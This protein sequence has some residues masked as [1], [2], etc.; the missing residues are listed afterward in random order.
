M[1]LSHLVGK[2]YK[3]RPS[4]ALLESHAILVR[5]GYIR[6][7]ANGIFSLLPPAHRIAQ[8]I[9]HII[10]EE[11]DRIGGQE[12]LMPVVLPA[13]LWK[14]SGRYDSVG[15]ELLRLSD[16]A[17]HQLL[18][19]MTHEEGVL[20]LARHE[21]TSYRNYPF[22][23][24]QFQTKFRDEPRA[25]GGL[26]R[27]REFTM[28][29][30]YSFHTS[31][32][33]MERYYRGCALAYA[34]IFARVGIPDVAVIQS[35]SG[36][37]GG[38]VAH[39]FVLLAECGEDTVV[40]CD[41]C[42]YLANAEVAVGHVASLPVADMLPIEPV[43]TPGANTI[44]DVAA[45]LHIPAD[46]IVKAVFF[47]ADSHGRPVVALVRGDLEI[48]LAKLSKLIRNVPDLADDSAIRAVGG[49]PGLGSPIGLRGCR[50]ISDITI[51]RA[52]NMVAGANKSNWHVRN[53]NLRRDV[54]DVEV[55]DIAVVREGDTCSH[56]GGLLHLRRGIEVGNI[57]QLG[58]KYT[59]SMNMRY[60]DADGREQTPIMGCY[61][62]GIGRLLACIAEARRDEHGPIWPISVS[63]WHVHI[64][65]L[66]AAKSAVGE[67]AARLYGEMIAAGVEAVLDDRNESSGTQFADADLLGV[68]L[69]L[70][71]SPRNMRNGVV[72]WQTRGTNEGGT[73]PLADAVAW[74]K[75]WVDA[76][77]QR[78]AEVADQLSQPI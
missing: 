55:A 40:I 70:I 71:L 10:R 18:L 50:V 75:K 77:I 44:E 52:F 27:T 9:M 41:G 45:C 16:R 12:V 21:A 15:P 64:S 59:E 14:E 65:A 68:P 33:D 69:R 54:P 42:S 43:H 38:K 73:V 8:K 11:M 36:M 72:E 24:Y 4:D 13:E 67:H 29:D 6:Q 7:V 25:R 66:N 32:G 53:F 19:A 78:Q 31:H 58:T 60:L 56:C 63:P 51:E 22:M 2:H 62:I 26:I 48:N 76:S 49:E 47:R 46:R 57:F 5:G 39:E 74:T 37:M 1:R 30:A 35:D 20:H 28:K 34:R 3:E 23:V 61:G 17:D